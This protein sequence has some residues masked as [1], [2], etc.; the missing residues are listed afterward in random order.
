MYELHETCCADVLIHNELN[1]H[2]GCYSTMYKSAGVL[3]VI[4]SP[5]PRLL[6]MYGLETTQKDRCDVGDL[7]NL[8]GQRDHMHP[9]QQT[10]LLC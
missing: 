5:E 9:Y 7:G 3:F 2:E 1:L 6:S 10:K 8:A 4:V